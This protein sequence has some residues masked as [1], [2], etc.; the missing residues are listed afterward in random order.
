[1]LWVFG[2]LLGGSSSPRYLT[3]F[4]RYFGPVDPDKDRWQEWQIVQSHLNLD[5]FLL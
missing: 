3:R 2:L 4:P 1:M 5:D